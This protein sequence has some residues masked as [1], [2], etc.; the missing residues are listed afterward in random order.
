MLA[1][2]PAGIPVRILLHG[3]EGA[4]GLM[5]PAGSALP[6]EQIAAVL[7]YIRREW[8]QAGAPVTAAMVADTRALT[9]GRLRPW[10]ND[11]L[12]AIGGGIAR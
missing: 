3:K 8:G 2:A 5:P 11:E 10:T 6:D 1:L 7:T 12:L 4:V 9:R